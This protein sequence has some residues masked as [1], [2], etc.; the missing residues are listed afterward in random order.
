MMLVSKS[1]LQSLRVT[2]VDSEGFC[3]SSCN[4]VRVVR[5]LFLEEMMKG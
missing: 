1:L 4:I 3:D 5:A 2:R